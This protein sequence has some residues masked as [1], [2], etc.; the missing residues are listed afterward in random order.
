MLQG[1]A[2]SL[3]SLHWNPDAEIADRILRPD[4]GTDDVFVGRELRGIGA[5]RVYRLDPI[6]L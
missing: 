6:T 4:A 1:Q 5:V 3:A 2:V